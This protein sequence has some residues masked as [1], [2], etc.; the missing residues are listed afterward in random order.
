MWKGTERKGN[1]TKR[2]ETKRNET[3]GKER[4][5]E[6]RKVMRGNEMEWKGQWV[7]RRN[8]GR[9]RM[10]YDWWSEVDYGKW[11]V[12]RGDIFCDNRNFIIVQN[13]C[14]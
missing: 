4:K 11:D 7:K 12:G 1:E 5:G 3:K 2:N 10:S 6:E 9:K 14:G 8:K 13:Q